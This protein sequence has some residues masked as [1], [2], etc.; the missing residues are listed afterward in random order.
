MNDTCVSTTLS[1]IPDL[2]SACDITAEFTEFTVASLDQ[3]CNEGA[4]NTAWVKYFNAQKAACT[5]EG[6]GWTHWNPETCCANKQK[7]FDETTKFVEEL[8]ANSTETASVSVVSTASPTVPANT[9]AS[10][11]ASA[12]SSAT[13]LNK[14]IFSLAAMVIVALYMN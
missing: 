14:G 8:I 9:K 12:K 11:T 2:M 7:C 1:L 13:S 3:Y 10:T 5:I 6:G 4:C